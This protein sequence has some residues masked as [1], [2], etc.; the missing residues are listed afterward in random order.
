MGYA[1]MAVW[2]T[3]LLM[4]CLVEQP[5][6]YAAGESGSLETVN[7][8][9]LERYMGRW[10]EIAK[11]PNRF[12]RKC[13]RDTTATYTLRPDG[14]VTVINRCLRE[15]G[16]EV[17]ARGLAKVVDPSTGAKLKVS[18]V[19][20]LGVRLFWGKYWVIGLDPNYQWALVGEPKRKYGWILARETALTSEQWETVHR[21]LGEKGYDPARFISTTHS[22]VSP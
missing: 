21:I 17:I 3:L 15:D 5:R 10:Y 7:R 8:V 6:I 12:Q 18:F 16:R 4:V 20:L 2:G 11:I 14:D 22:S 9:E 1:R 13:D 19:S